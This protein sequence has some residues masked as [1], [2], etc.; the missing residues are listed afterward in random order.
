M[1][2]LIKRRPKR[3]KSPISL[4]EKEPKIEIELGT[5][6]EETLNVLE[7]RLDYTSDIGKR[8]LKFNYERA[9]LVYFVPLMDSVKLNEH[10]IKPLLIE[11]E[12]KISEI[13]Q[14][15][16]ITP[17][18]DLNEMISLM[19]R[20][21]SVLLI[22]NDPFV[23]AIDSTKTATREVNQALNEKVI[24]GSQESFVESLDKNLNMM[25]QKFLDGS[26]IVRYIEVGS[27]SRT[28]VAV[29]Y[30]KNIANAEICNMIIDRIKQIEVDGVDSGSIIEEALEDSPLSPF[31]Q[32]LN[33]ERPDRVMGNL[34]EGR[35]A[36]LTNGNSSALIAPVNF[37]TFYQSPEDY[38]TRAL[39][40]SFFRLLRVFSFFV[41][42]SLPAIYIATISFHYEL[43]PLDLVFTVKGSLENVPFPPIVEAFIMVLILEL[44]KEAS[45]RLPSSIAQTIGV[46]G[47]LVI[48]TAIVE[49]S[50]V[51]NMMIIVIALTAVSSFVVPSNEMSTTLRILSFPMMIGAAAFGYLGIVFVLVL[52]VMHLVI[53]ESITMPYLIPFAPFKFSGLKDVFIRMHQLYLNERPANAK[54]QKRQRQKAIRNWDSNE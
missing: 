21:A 35:M 24:R 8:W 23:Y 5:N 51:S 31:P 40:G 7:E 20:G 54:P 46:V 38:N 9:L 18:K 26:L 11:K 32:L 50:L 45:L 1:A 42:M 36:V 13:I 53:L 34:L 3:K 37:F 47:G 48:G 16:S 10:V 15:A 39:Y 17:T 2:L 30:L 28:R 33:T 14:A 19:S 12:G 49:A 43:I 4:E 44:L 52:I 27:I 25:R 41:A 29:L 6:I 22:E